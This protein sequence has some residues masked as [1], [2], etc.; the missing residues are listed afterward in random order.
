MTTLNFT[1]RFRTP[2]AVTSGHASDGLD[3]RVD[4]T[5]LLPASS[6]KGVMRAESLVALGLP[7]TLVD[8]VFGAAA[9]SSPS[10]WSWTD[11]RFAAHEIDHRVRIK[12]GE[13]GRSEEGALLMAEY[14]WASTATF[15]VR[16]QG[17]ID[18]GEQAHHR[19]LLRAVARSVTS[20]GAARRR[21]QGWVSITDDQAWT[22]ADTAALLALS[23]A[24]IYA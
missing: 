11:A 13:Q 14:V 12:V 8:A 9:P 6:L 4:Q 17:P 24:G 1:I 18:P 21:G 7:R 16:R 22:P 23:G 20:L 15:A 19:L 5:A 2:F 10:P 3:S